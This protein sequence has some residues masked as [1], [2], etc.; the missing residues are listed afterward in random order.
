M[1]PNKQQIA[2]NIMSQW[3]LNEAVQNPPFVYSDPIHSRNEGKPHSFFVWQSNPSSLVRQ[4]FLHFS[5]SLQT[6][7]PTR[8]HL[9][10]IPNP[11]S[12]N[13]TWLNPILPDLAGKGTE[14]NV[15]EERTETGA[16]TKLSW[17]YYRNPKIPVRTR[18]QEQSSFSFSR[19]LSPICY[20][21]SA[22]YYAEHSSSSGIIFRIHGRS[23]HVHTSTPF[24]LIFN[25]LSF[26]SFSQIPTHSYSFQERNRKR[27]TL[28][29]FNQNQ[30]NN[31]IIRANFQRLISNF[32]AAHLSQSGCTSYLNW[33]THF[34]FF[35]HTVF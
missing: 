29:K 2:S 34:G 16:T 27:T 14:I 30:Q 15:W 26:L 5:P 31:A 35:F 6:C 21:N 10:T 23:R 22:L 7:N 4:F 9:Q 25:S 18:E 3:F 32:N 11:L 33:M 24:M 28:S 17:N 1:F 13:L 12:C 20:T 19:K 8:R